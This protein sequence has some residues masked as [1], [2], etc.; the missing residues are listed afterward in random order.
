[1]VYERDMLIAG[2]PAD[3][4]LAFANT[5]SWR[6][7]PAPSEKLH[8]LP[9]LLGWLEASVGA[10]AAATD[11]VRAW[12]RE[13]PKKAAAVFADAIAIREGLFGAFAAI[14]AGAAV[15]D[16]D[17]A[18]LK[19]ALAEAPARS[20][21]ARADGAYAWRIGQ[22]KPTAPY[23]LA[24][25]LWSAGDLF[26]DKGQRRIRQCANEKCLWLFVDA[27]KSGTRRWC[28]MASCGN[29]AKAQRHYAKVKHEH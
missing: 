29:R 28:D 4:C 17:F 26:V 1:M 25:V 5:L 18:V 2:L 9:D 11:E 15:R 24:P 19:K 16:Q 23:L 27:S 3:L 6:G 22:M 21:L 12:S 7:S 13:H 10:G 20:E 8:A 14:A